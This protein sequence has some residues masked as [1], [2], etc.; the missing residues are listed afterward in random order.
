MSENNTIKLPEDKVRSRYKK[1]LALIPRVVD[2]CDIL[3]IYD[4]TTEPFRIFKKR[5]D[6]FFRWANEY[7]GEKDIETLSGVYDFVKD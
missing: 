4:N 2:I 6:I 7:W 3:H 1:A 5:K